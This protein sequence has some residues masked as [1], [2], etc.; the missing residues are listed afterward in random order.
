[1]PVHAFAD[2]SRRG[3]TYLVAAVIVEPAKLRHLRR[4][5][6]TLLLPGQR[7]LH[8]NREKEPRRRKLIDAMATMPADAMLYQSACGRH[9][10]P[11]RQA[12]VD[13]LTR[14]L[15]AMDAHRLVMDS[16][17]HRDIEDAR[18]IR[19][20]LGIRAR[21]TNF[22]YEHVDSTIEPL[23]WLSDAVA[24]CFNARGGWRKKTDKLVTRV[25]HVDR[26]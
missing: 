6:R 9:D 7:E 13:R 10:E 14:E 22:V 19:A 23:L 25:V 8:F 18:T 5:L 15:L 21:D 11:A 26:P 1:M 16:R 20:A 3:S 24:W 17:Q 12:C 2:E 4:D